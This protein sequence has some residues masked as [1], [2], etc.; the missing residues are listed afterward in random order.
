M[1]ES[2]LRH[3]LGQVDPTVTVLSAGLYPGGQPATSHG[4]AT[5][6]DR[7]FD[8]GLHRSQQIGPELL[9]GA[10]LILGMAREHVREAA[11]LEPSAIGRTFTLKELVRLAETN[12]GRRTGEAFRDWLSR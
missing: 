2:F 11:V 5:M 4:V 9:Q 7:G 1:A 6:A 10:D 3:R 12:G 8:L